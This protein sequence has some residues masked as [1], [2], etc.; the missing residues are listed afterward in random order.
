LWN[1]VSNLAISLPIAT[2]S[3]ITGCGRAET[4][5]L[6]DGRVEFVKVKSK[7][8]ERGGGSCINPSN[9]R[10]RDALNDLKT[11]KSVPS[12]A[13]FGLKSPQ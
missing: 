9:F 5:W 6:P 3:L 12:E 13:L 4:V 7:R 11:P 8:R 2:P 1:E 10:R